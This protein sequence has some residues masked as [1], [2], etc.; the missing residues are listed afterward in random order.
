MRDGGEEARDVAAKL[1][2]TSALVDGVGQK[3][4]CAAFRRANPRT[5]FDL[6]RSYK[7]IQGRALPRSA[8]VYEDWALVCGLD[9]PGRWIA[10]C[11]LDEF[12]A[13]ICAARGVERAVLLRRAGLGTEARPGGVAVAAR[14]RPPRGA[15]DGARCR[16]AS[17]TGA[18]S[19]P[20]APQPAWRAAA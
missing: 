15:W 16:R 13:E 10:A 6:A 17:R 11:T 5:G 14:A 18:A 2:V 4:L 12:V 7:W 8:E 9:R 20:R 1:R 19:C 3:S